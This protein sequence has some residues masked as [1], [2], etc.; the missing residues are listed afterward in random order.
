MSKE[1]Y[2]VLSL[3]AR[4]LFSLLG[5]LIVLRSF[6]WLFS[7]H[8]ERRRL[9]RRLPNAGLIGE[10]VVLSGGAGL[11]E[12][13]VVNCTTS[14][15]QPIAGGFG[16]IREVIVDLN[17]PAGFASSNTGKTGFGS[18]KVPRSQKVYSDFVEK[19]MSAID[20]HERYL[21]TCGYPLDDGCPLFY[22][23]WGSPMS[24]ST[25]TGRIRKLFY[26]HF[27]PDL[28]K[29]CEAQGTWAENAPYIEA[30]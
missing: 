16:R 26:E 4:Y 12:G 9:R 10:M 23:K 25:Y 7:D 15:I 22:N 18:I 30:P 11:R 13:E 28:R 1:L 27:L 2:E 21:C 3:A 6:F 20:A 14:N 24:V 29:I 8:S 17:E 19:F 5:M